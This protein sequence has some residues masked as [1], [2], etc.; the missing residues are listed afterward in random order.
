MAVNEVANISGTYGYFL[1]D[2]KKNA[3]AQID[4][5]PVEFCSVNSTGHMVKLGFAE[6]LAATVFNPSPYAGYLAMAPILPAS[7]YAIRSM[8]VDGASLKFESGRRE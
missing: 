1:A 6:N 7:L 5:K 4:L 3:N 8:E 2:F